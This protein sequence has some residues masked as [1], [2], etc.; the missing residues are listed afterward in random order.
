M[1]DAGRSPEPGARGSTPDPDRDALVR[2]LLD[3]AGVDPIYAAHIHRYV[4][5]GSVLW[6]DCCGSACDPCILVFAR[7]VDAVRAAE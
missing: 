3:E 1:S 5:D 6:G 7:I 2:R 4:E